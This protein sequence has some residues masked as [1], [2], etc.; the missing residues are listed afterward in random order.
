MFTFLDNLIYSGE[1]VTSF[2]QPYLADNPFVRMIL[3]DQASLV[4]NE[5]TRIVAYASTTVPVL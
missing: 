3:S 4:C 2:G 5:N 1:Y